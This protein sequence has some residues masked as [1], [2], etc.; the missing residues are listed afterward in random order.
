MQKGE[1][2]KSVGLVHR[3]CARPCND[4]TGS[5]YDYGAAHNGVPRGRRG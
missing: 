4:F 2:L 1:R 5:K 3:N